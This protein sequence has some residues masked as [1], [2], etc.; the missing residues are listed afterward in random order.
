MNPLHP[1]LQPKAYPAAIHPKSCTVY[2]ILSSVPVGFLICA[3]SQSDTL[4]KTNFGFQQGC[5]LRSDAIGT[6]S[7][8]VS[9]CTYIVFSLKELNSICSMVSGWRISFGSTA[10]AEIRAPHPSFRFHALKSVEQ[11]APSRREVVTCF[12]VLWGQRHSFHDFSISRQ[13]LTSSQTMKTFRSALCK[14]AIFEA[15]Q[16]HAAD[17]ARKA[18]V[19]MCRLAGVG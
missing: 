11:R 4:G 14:G 12:R 13:V 10:Q 7:H 6:Q 15:C 9:C 17:P 3:M 16:L 1:V 18:G 19:L 5:V 8:I 2:S